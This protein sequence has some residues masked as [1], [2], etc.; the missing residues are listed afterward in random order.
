LKQDI[1]IQSRQDN[2]A[3]SLFFIDNN[4]H[5]AAA[6]LDLY[7]QTFTADYNDFVPMN[8]V[9]YLLSD[10]AYQ[11]AIDEDDTGDL[12]DGDSDVNTWHSD[13]LEMTALYKGA[14]YH[15]YN[16]YSHDY[17]GTGNFTGTIY[18]PE[19]PFER[20]VFEYRHYEGQSLD[21]GT[22]YQYSGEKYEW[23]KP[24]ATLPSDVSDIA[25]KQSLAVD[26]DHDGSRFTFAGDD[27]SKVNEYVYELW[28]DYQ[29]NATDNA[30]YDWEDI[31]TYNIVCWTWG[32]PGTELDVSKLEDETVL[33]EPVYEY[34]QS[35]KKG[36]L[37]WDDKYVSL[38]YY[39][40]IS[41]YEQAIDMHRND[42]Q[43]MYERRDVGMWVGGDYWRTT[44]SDITT[45][46]EIPVP[47]PFLLWDD[48]YRTV[49]RTK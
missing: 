43:D 32:N 9:S 24:Y 35:I 30:T 39:P 28:G 38:R 42:L 17:N 22:Y 6:Y 40:G 27:L 41:T 20:Y 37:R 47:R 10:T 33:P 36:E 34:I 49:V 23:R 44:R 19:A 21:N 18:V 2:G 3:Y 48:D 29:L 31:S 14:S 46:S 26:I 13:D 8:S 1:S 12:S 16:W 45:P 4:A 7:A 15:F 11:F 25:G 5:T